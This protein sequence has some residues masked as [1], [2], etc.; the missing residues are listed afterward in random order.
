MAISVAAN[1]AESTPAGGEDVLNRVALLD[2]EIEAID[3]KAA[4]LSDD[5]LALRVQSTDADRDLQKVAGDLERLQVRK[6]KLHGKTEENRKAIDALDSTEKEAAEK[7]KQAE[8]AIADAENE[9]TKIEPQIP[10]L[11]PL[12]AIAKAKSDALHDQI[13]EREIELEKLSADRSAL[14]KKIETM[15]KDANQWVSFKDQVAAIFHRRCVACHNVRNSQG[16]YNMA[17]YDAIISES[18]SGHAI[19]VGNAD[20]S[21]L[22]EMIEDGTMPLDAEPL[23]ESEIETIRRWVQLGARLDIDA[24]PSAPLIRL[25]PRAK[26]PE[27]PQSYPAPIPVT[28]LQVSSDG[29]LLASS[30]YH[31]VLLWS[32]DGQGAA[33]LKRRITNL[34]QRTHAIDFHPTQSWLAVASG[35]PGALGEVKLFDWKSGE[36]IAD[37]LVSEDEIFDVA[38][39]PDGLRLASCGA[40]GS[41][42]IFDRDDSGTWT[43]SIIQDHADWVN[44]IRW[45]ND[46]SMLVS[47]SRDKT[48]KVFDASTRKLMITFNGHAQNVSDA[49]F[50][51]D[52]KRIA[53]AGDDMKV[54]I[55]TI[56][57]GKQERD[58]KAARSGLAGLDNFGE[59]VI[60]FSADNLIRVH[61]CSDGKIIQSVDLPAHWVSSFAM[62]TDHQT[63][64]FGDHSGQ[65]HRASMTEPAKIE[66]TWTAAP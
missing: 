49:V 51:A 42:A 33:T 17:T 26:H 31:E 28:A 7:I 27:P 24:D 2:T 59:H 47:A 35:T 32:L 45:S 53:S 30:G 19:S 50:T 60:S 34:A 22:V 61:N 48:S 66:T 6:E 25:M 62:T 9:I 29:N 4:A 18:D 21:L 14:T 56:A 52:G 12:I 44:S 16:R 58:I 38:F 55:W 5:I 43:P 41:I 1:A 36:L 64:F 39:S 57:N 54:R 8:K 11:V 46:G 37:L 23:T 20:Q 3:K 15:L 10:E 13:R 65:V 40:D 63:I